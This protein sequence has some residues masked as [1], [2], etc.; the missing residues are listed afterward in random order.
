MN[1][2]EKRTRDEDGKKN[3][4]RRLKFQFQVSILTSADI[5]HMHSCIQQKKSAH[6]TVMNTEQAD[7]L[8][9]ILNNE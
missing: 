7:I 4:L 6:E 9:P 2:K 5:T 1:E 8:L 3:N